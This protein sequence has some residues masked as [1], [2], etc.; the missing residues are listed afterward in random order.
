M[1]IDLSELRQIADRLFDHLKQNGH[2][3]VTVEHDYYWDVPKSSRYDAYHPPSDHTLGQ[4][5]DDL[6]ELRKITNG[7]S[8][9]L[10]YALVWL[11]SMLRAVGEELVT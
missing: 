8:E 3:T 10:S 5:S 6:S 2:L 4:L 1:E 7:N 11:G 9:P